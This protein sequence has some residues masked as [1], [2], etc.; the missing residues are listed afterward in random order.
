MYFF[1]FLILIGCGAPVIKKPVTINLVESNSSLLGSFKSSQNEEQSGL[2]TNELSVETGF[3]ELYFD[4]V[5]EQK[6]SDNN[7]IIYKGQIKTLIKEET[8][9][10]NPKYE[11]E[12]LPLFPSNDIVYLK[13]SYVNEYF[14]LPC[15]FLAPKKYYIFEDNTF[16]EVLYKENEKTEITEEIKEI[17]EEKTAEKTIPDNN[18]TEKPILPKTTLDSIESNQNNINTTEPIPVTTPTVTVT[19]ITIPTTPSTAT[20]TP[21]ATPTTSPE[22]I[23]ETLK[24]K[25]LLFIAMSYNLCLDLIPEDLNPNMF[26]PIYNKYC[27][28]EETNALKSLIN[29]NDASFERPNFLPASSGEAF[30]NYPQELMP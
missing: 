5:P 30:I 15:S 20:A 6:C 10:V 16:K 22:N 19:P 4:Y 2:L 26:I 27:H 9:T 3:L 23:T 7:L 21:T 1:I 12:I 18:I 13:Y 14:K 28:K 17:I 8:S 11:E 25:K 29:I 24:K